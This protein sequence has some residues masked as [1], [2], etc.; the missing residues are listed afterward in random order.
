MERWLTQRLAGSLG[1]SPGR[2]DGVCANVEFPFPGRLIGGA[3]AIAS[4]IEPEA[5]PWPPE[6]SV[7]PLL[8]VVQR[9]VDE[10]WLAQLSAHLGGGSSDHGRRFGRLRV[11]A[12]L[13]DHY[14]VRRPAMLHA[15]TRGEDVDGSGAPLA[16]AFGWQAELWRRLRAEIGVRSPAERLSEACARVREA[17]EL[18]PLPARLSLFGLTRLPAS[19]VQALGALAAGRE[20]HLFLLHPSPALWSLIGQ[21][22]PARAIVRRAEDGTAAL[23]ENRLL[24]SWGVDSRELQLVVESADPWI[25]H[26]HDPSRR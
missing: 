20:V 17:P 13:Y 22:E 23:A 25:D 24:A 7:W 15:W 10:P 14:G 19:Y 12:E 3:I 4:G 18:L 5:D 1:A 11:I 2:G 16:P 9:C 6:R 8:D 26:H 21:R